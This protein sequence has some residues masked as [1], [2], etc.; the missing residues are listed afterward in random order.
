MRAVSISWSNRD[1]RTNEE[2][3]PNLWRR[4]IPARGIALSSPPIE[5]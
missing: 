4:E 3:A 2:P 1:A 5:A